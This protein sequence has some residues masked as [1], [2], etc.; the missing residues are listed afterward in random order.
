MKPVASDA[1]ALAKRK[2]ILTSSASDAQPIGKLAAIDVIININYEANRIANRSIQEGMVA[3]H[4]R[5]VYAIP[6]H[7][8]YMRTGYSSE[9]LLAEAAHQL[10]DE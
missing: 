4:A 6:S 5:L 7:R 9:P 2:L 3:R 8:G 1:L 10:V